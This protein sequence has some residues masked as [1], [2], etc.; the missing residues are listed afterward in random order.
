VKTHRY[1][2]GTRLWL[3]NDDLN[4]ERLYQITPYSIGQLLHVISVDYPNNL[5]RVLMKKPGASSFA[6]WSNVIGT[7]HLTASTHATTIWAEQLAK[8][9]DLHRSTIY[10]VALPVKGLPDVVLSYLLLYSE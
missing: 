10:N 3:R 5:G 7:L 2:H 4:D 9:L 6:S 8:S 1:Q